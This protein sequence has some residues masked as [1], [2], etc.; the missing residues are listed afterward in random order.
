MLYATFEARRKAGPV[1]LSVLNDHDLAELSWSLR[2]PPGVAHDDLPEPNWVQADLER[3][4]VRRRIRLNELIVAAARPATSR[5]RLARLLGTTADH[6]VQRELAQGAAVRPD[7]LVDR[8]VRHHPD[9]SPDAR[10]LA[11]A[12]RSA[13]FAAAAAVATSAARSR[14]PQLGSDGVAMGRGRPRSAATSARAAE[15]EQRRRPRASAEPRRAHGRL[16]AASTRRAGSSAA[17][18]GRIDAAP[19]RR[20]RPL[21]AHRQAWTRRASS[22]ARHQH[23]RRGRYAAV[24]AGRAARDGR[25]HL[26][27]VLLL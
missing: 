9:F 19:S 25:N 8:I 2:R 14:L 22:S 15:R 13:R 21:T 26:V 7:G 12:P 23:G 5:R 4:G 3:M 11:P 6:A 16:G 18:D 27:S 1:D 24:G 10:P 20:A 17:L